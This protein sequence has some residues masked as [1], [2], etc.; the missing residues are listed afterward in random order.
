MGKEHQKR[1]LA[2]LMAASIAIPTPV[3]AASPADFSDFPNNWQPM[4]CPMR[5]AMAYLVVTT[6]RS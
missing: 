3:L 1:V 6:E 5:L 4:L 2:A